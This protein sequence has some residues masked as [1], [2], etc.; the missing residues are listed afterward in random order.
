MRKLEGC[1]FL[2]RKAVAEGHRQFLGHIGILGHADEVV[3][4][5]G[6]QA[7]R[8]HVEGEVLAMCV[9][10][11]DQ[12]LEQRPSDHCQLVRSLRHR[13]LQ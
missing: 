5:R 2:Q 8:Q 13:V 1:E 3:P 6:R 7:L 11:A 4:G 12:Y 9:A 10:I